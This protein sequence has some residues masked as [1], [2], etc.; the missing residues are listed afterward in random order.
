VERR[1]PDNGR[2]VHP[3][4]QFDMINRS[5][6]TPAPSSCDRGDGPEWGSLPLEERRVLV[7]HLRDLRYATQIGVSTVVPVLTQGA[8]RANSSPAT[9]AR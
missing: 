6:G 1:R 4:M 8:F 7:E 3:E 2:I 9:P 5:V